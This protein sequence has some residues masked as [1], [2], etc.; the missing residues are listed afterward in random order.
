MTIKTSALGGGGPPKLA[1]DLT[2][3]SSLGANR[4]FTTIAA[5][6]ASSGLTTALSLTGKFSIDLLQFSLL[7]AENITVKL[8]ID[9]VVIWNDTFSVVGTTLQLFG[10]DSSTSTTISTMQCEASLLLEIQT[11]TDTDISLDYT[12]R[13]VL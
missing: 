4:G 6:D 8:T 1:P 10:S 9:G 12:A 5:I 11:A 3:P 13:P 7:T 2:Y